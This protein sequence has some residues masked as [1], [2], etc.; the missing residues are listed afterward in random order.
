M[1][2]CALISFTS[3]ILNIA[4]LGL[5]WGLNET[6]IYNR[7]MNVSLLFWTKFED[8]FGGVSSTDLK[9]ADHAA[10]T[11]LNLLLKTLGRV[12]CRLR[13]LLIPVERRQSSVNIQDGMMEDTI[14][15]VWN[16]WGPLSLIMLLILIFQKPFNVFFA[17]FSISLQSQ[18]RESSVF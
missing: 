9:V 6:I 17:F 13:V 14:I 4:L 3:G 16:G 7:Y 11:T 2:H 12:G 8:R 15:I 5:L 1:F 10:Q 18:M